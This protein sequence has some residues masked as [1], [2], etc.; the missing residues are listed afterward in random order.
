MWMSELDRRF[1]AV[2]AER[3]GGKYRWVGDEMYARYGFRQVRRPGGAGAL[4]VYGVHHTVGGKT[5]DDECRFHAEGRGWDTPGY[6][7]TIRPDG[8]VEGIAPIG[9]LLT[10]GA[11]PANN[12][13]TAHVSCIGNYQLNPPQAV[14][15]N[16]LYVVLCALD[17]VYGGKPWRGHRELLQASTVCPGKHLQAHVALMRGLDWG[18]RV[19]RPEEYL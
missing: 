12:G 6:A 11:G 4:R 9:G 10:Y 7:M 5:A 18:A 2:L 15:L 8:L 1:Y 3:L 19:P 13:R 16:S 17:D 14:M